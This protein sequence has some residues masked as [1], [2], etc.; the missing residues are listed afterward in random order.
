LPFTAL[1]ALLAGLVLAPGAS[2]LESTGQ[3]SGTVTDTGGHPL[4]GIEVCASSEATSISENEGCEKTSANGEFTI[5]G[6]TVGSYTV[7]FGSP[8]GGTLNY[9]PQFYKEASSA[10]AAQQVAVSAGLTTTGINAKLVEGGKISG[11]VTDAATHAPLEVAIVCARPVSGEA[12]LGQCATTN[13]G[14]E[15]TIVGLADG[16]YQVAFI[17]GKYAVQY[18][19]GKSALSE[20]NAVSVTAGA[21]TAGIDAALS[22]SAAGPGSGGPLPGVPGAGPGSVTPGMKGPLTGSPSGP[23]L[24]VRKEADRPRRQARRRA[25]S[26]QVRRG[27][28]QGVDR[29]DGKDRQAPQGGKISSEGQDRHPCQGLLHGGAGQGRHLCSTS[30]RRGTQAAGPCEGSPRAREADGLRGRRKDDDSAGTHQLSPKLTA[31]I[32]SVVSEPSGQVLDLR[33]AQSDAQPTQG[34]LP[35]Q[36]VEAHIAWIAGSVGKVGEPVLSRAQRMRHAAA[37]WTREH[38]TRVQL[39]ALWLTRAAR[40]E[41]NGPC[42]LEYDEDLLLAGVAVWRRAALACGQRHVIQSG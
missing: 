20:A 34:N 37:G 15:Y 29:V 7:Q 28:V 17:H 40:V 11:R 10:A 23:L 41:L 4:S 31:P 35:R 36:R 5:T 14:G 21:T 19:N 39:M 12:A 32:A 8:F 3:I 18:Y 22:A 33:R 6:L 25:A 42:A 1:A 38:V 2:A 26:P 30:D 24:T 27:G 13:A 9:V 16:S